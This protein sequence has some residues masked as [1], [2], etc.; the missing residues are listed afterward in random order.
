LQTNIQPNTPF[1][2]KNND[3]SQWGFVSNIDQ[4]ARKVEISIIKPP[5]KYIKPE[6]YP[7]PTVY[8]PISSKQYKEMTGKL[9]P[10]QLGGPEIF[11]EGSPNFKTK[12]IVYTSKDEAVEG[13]FK[14]FGQDDKTM[15]TVTLKGGTQWSGSLW[16]VKIKTPVGR[17]PAAPPNAPSAKKQKTDQAPQPA[18]D[19][20]GPVD[21]EMSDFM[22]SIGFGKYANSLIEAGY[23]DLE[24]L[25]NEVDLEKLKE[26][27]GKF[28]LSPHVEKLV[29]KV[30][31]F[32]HP[33]VPASEPSFAADDAA[34]VTSDKADSLASLALS[35]RSI[36]SSSTPSSSRI[37]ML[38]TAGRAASICSVSNVSS[39]S[40]L[41]S[42][43]SADEITDPLGVEKV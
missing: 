11:E 20:V 17:P 4:E 37:A 13:T 32:R 5:G 12:V 43:D 31:K 23:D 40:Q 14:G 34:S 7:A 22:V 36:G 8:K 33:T 10:P 42:T 30:A 41:S 26:D 6:C 29:R 19:A 1:Q 15:C 21:K 18:A 38:D 27:C 3:G 16:L 35:R 25:Q 24:D 39:V 9:Q 28:M 2:Y